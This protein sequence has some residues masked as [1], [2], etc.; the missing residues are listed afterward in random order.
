METKAHRHG[1]SLW[2]DVDLES[3]L[4]SG[5]WDLSRVG[6]GGT[7]RVLVPVGLP[8]ALW[9]RRGSVQG[10]YARRVTGWRKNEHAPRLPVS[11]IVLP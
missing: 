6:C 5:E 1:G 11:I 7:E 3:G 8:D 2:E 10:R 4:T 9:G